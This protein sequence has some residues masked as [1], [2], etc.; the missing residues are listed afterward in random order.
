MTQ[1]PFSNTGGAA[2]L[3]FAKTCKQSL[4]FGETLIVRTRVEARFG[5]PERGAETIE[6]HGFQQ[7]IDG[8]HIESARGVS[9]VGG[10]KDDLGQILAWPQAFEHSKSIPARHLNIEHCNIG[11]Q[12]ANE[13]ERFAAVFGGGAE[14]R[15]RDA[16]ERG[17]QARQGDRFIVGK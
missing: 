17:L 14:M 6:T 9:V 2:C 8:V 3:L 11:V 10:R 1:K 15:L 13:F 12:S 5:P 16:L 7:I 4:Q